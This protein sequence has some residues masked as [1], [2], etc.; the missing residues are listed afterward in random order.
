MSRPI[1]IAGASARDPSTRNSAPNTKPAMAKGVRASNFEPVRASTA[2]CQR[3][4]TKTVTS[5]A[6]HGSD[7]PHLNIEVGHSGL[8]KPTLAT[9][10][11]GCTKGLGI[12]VGAAGGSGRALGAAAVA[13]ARGGA[14]VPGRGKVS[15]GG[16]GGPR[17]WPA[18]SVLDR[19]SCTSFAGL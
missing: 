3:P 6:T 18:V 16:R 9:A 1:I 17:F 5:S 11:P 13:V 15:G 8:S 7:A 10:G 19:V 2:S 4:P 14:V 12:A